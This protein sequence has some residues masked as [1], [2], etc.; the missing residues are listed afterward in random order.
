MNGIKRIAPLQNEQKSKKNNKKRIKIKVLERENGNKLRE[1][2]INTY[3]FRQL[4]GVNLLFKLHNSNIC[5]LLKKMEP[6][7]L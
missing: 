6:L 5:R 1:S 4:T 7:D 2:G 3:F